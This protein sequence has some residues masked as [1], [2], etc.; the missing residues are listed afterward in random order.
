[1]AKHDLKTI[2]SH[3][4]KLNHDN[5][6]FTNSND[7][8]TPMECVKEMVDSIPQTF[9]EKENLRILDSGCGNGNFHAYIQTK[10]PLESLYFN[11]I[12]EK[13]IKNAVEYFG[14]AINI[15]KMD[16]LDFQTFDYDLV[17]SNPPYA[18]F[19]GDKRA[20]KNHNL[21]RAFIQ[22]ALDI[23]KDGGY[24][25]FIVPDNWMSFSD[26]NKLPSEL[27]QYQFIHLNIH[28]AKKYFKRVGSSFTWFLLHKVPN[29]RKFKVENHYKRVDKVETSIDR[30]VNFIPLYYSDVVKSLINKTVNA[31]VPKYEVE[32]TSDLHRTTKADLIS[33]VKDDAHPFRLIHTPKQTVWSS[34]P[35]KYQ[36]G[37]K[38]FLS[39]SDR[40]GAGV[41]NCGM[42]QSIAFIRCKSKNDAIKIQKELST[43]VYRAINNITR[44][45]NFNN[46]RV[47]Q[48][49]PLL[50]HISL[51]EDEQKLVNYYQGVI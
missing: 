47:L 31:N 19:C 16:F 1:M 51:N 9:W 21:S 33:T 40:Y 28:G 42:T 27:S 4:N 35:H 32:T 18:K 48:R 5:S 30:G 45:G 50:K 34:R 10:Y 25:L 39:L 41:D 12:N 8:C 13:R 23:T 37:W 44:Y 38:V 11:D 7:I 2:F 14:D 24:I 17:V 49:L 15:L 26:R 29:K 3:F 46:I 6:H 43:P 22:K 20:S 36:E